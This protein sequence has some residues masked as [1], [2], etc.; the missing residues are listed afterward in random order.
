MLNQ[1]LR[2]P[3]GQPQTLRCPIQCMLF[4]RSGKRSETRAVPS[5]L[6]AS[7][8]THHTQLRYECDA[9]ADT[10]R[11]PPRIIRLPSAGPGRWPRCQWPLHLPVRRCLEHTLGNASALSL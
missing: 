6:A 7:L 9:F 8:I 5:A 2:M 10:G 4:R 11:R 3:Y 1:T